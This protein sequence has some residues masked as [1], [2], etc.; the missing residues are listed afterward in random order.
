[1]KNNKLPNKCIYR[2]TVDT[3]TCEGKFTAQTQHLVSAVDL[4]CH[5]T[6]K[7]DAI[8]GNWHLQIIIVFLISLKKIWFVF[9]SFA[10]PDTR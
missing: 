1:M 8:I 3:D 6:Y 9:N 5:D 2:Y 7:G 4:K 10:V